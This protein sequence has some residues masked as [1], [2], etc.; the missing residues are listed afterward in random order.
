MNNAPALANPAI[1]RYVMAVG[2][3]DSI[4]TMTI[5][6]DR[7]P[8]FS[9]WPKRGA[10]RGVDLVAHREPTSRACASGTASST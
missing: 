2:A 10:T 4:G 7:V 3:S 9:P 1:D 5:E 8:A 6:D